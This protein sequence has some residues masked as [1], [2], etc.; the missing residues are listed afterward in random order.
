MKNISLSCNGSRFEWFTAPPEECRF[1]NCADYNIHYYLCAKA[2]FERWL[3]EHWIS[4]CKTAPWN[5]NKALLCSVG[6][7]IAWLIIW[8]T[9]PPVECR[10]TINNCAEYDIHHDLCAT[11]GF[12]RWIR[13]HCISYCKMAPCNGNESPNL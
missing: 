3:R 12:E 6:W 2:G 13:D 9:A 11:A 1:N 10:D 8:F 7:L 5:G 4:Y